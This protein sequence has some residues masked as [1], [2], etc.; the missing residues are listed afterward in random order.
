MFL[1]FVLI[2]IIACAVYFYIGKMTERQKWIAINRKLEQNLNQQTRLHD[3]N[4]IYQYLTP[5]HEPNNEPTVHKTVNTFNIEF[6][7]LI[8]TLN[9]NGKWDWQHKNKNHE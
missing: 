9:A 8:I 7:G 1:L 5:Y 2:L 4:I 3:I 6:D